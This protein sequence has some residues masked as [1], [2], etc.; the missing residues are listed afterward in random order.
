MAALSVNW[1]ISISGNVLLLYIR[2]YTRA[3][4]TSAY[5]VGML[6]H[7][8]AKSRYGGK[9]IRTG[10]LYTDTTSGFPSQ[11]SAIS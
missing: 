1:S 6:S 9:K 11:L 3:N 2:L 7:L 4:S 5:P 10:Q 8:V